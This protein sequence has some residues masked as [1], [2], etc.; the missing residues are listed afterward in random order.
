MHSIAERAWLAGF[1]DGEGTI[2]VQTLGSGKYGGTRYSVV[3][4]VTNTY[5]PIMEQIANEWEGARLYKRNTRTG[6]KQALEVRWNTQNALG[7]LREVAPFL[8]VKDKQAQLALEYAAT[9]NPDEHRS[10]AVSTETLQKREQIRLQ[11]KAYNA[12]AGAPEGV[13]INIRERAPLTCQR[14]GT[15]FTDYI[16]A[17]KYCSKDCA[18][19]AGREF[20]W[21]RHITERTCPSC[22]NTFKTHSPKQTYCSLSCGKKGSPDIPKGT[23]KDRDRNIPV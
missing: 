10:R 9:L 16:K 14:C 13:E 20:Y 3:V 5:V 1:I 12:R 11:L 4:S 2:R 19:K 15:E 21:Q 22:G 8:R 7:V 23:R 6:W 17:R 18:M